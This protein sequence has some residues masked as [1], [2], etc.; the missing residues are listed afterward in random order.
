MHS[1]ERPYKVYKEFVPVRFS[2]G[3]GS[4]VGHTMVGV[5]HTR[6]GV[7]QGLQGHMRTLLVFR[8]NKSLYQGILVL[9]RRTVLDTP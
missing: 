4:G 8:S 7:G 1:G 6:V 5:G 9:V 2:F 3:T